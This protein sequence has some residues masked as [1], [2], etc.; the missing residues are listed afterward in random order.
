MLLILLDIH[1]NSLP[2]D[3]VLKAWKEVVVFLQEFVENNFARCASQ[4]V[5]HSV[6]QSV[7]LSILGRRL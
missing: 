3:R 4:S 5:S 1:R 7:N 2:P 6:T